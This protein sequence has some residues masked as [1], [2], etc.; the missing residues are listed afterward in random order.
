VLP[1]LLTHA[2]PAWLGAIA[3]AAVL[4]TE[5][6]TSDAIHFMLATSATKDN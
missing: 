5:V 6:D 1:T 3:Q 4:S 2:L